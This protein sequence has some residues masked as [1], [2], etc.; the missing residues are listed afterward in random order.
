MN[1]LL[2]LITPCYL[3]RPFRWLLG[4]FWLSNLGDG[5]LLAAGPLLVASQTRSPGLVALATILQRLPWM[6][7]G[8][9]A[10]FVADRFDRRM[11]AL[12]TDGA[13]IAVLAFLGGLVALDRVNI[14]VVLV[15]LF[16]IGVAEAFS[17]TAIDAM[18]PSLVADE[19]LG[20]ANARI[21]F[22]HMGLN[23]LA[24]PPVGALLFG[25]G[26]AVPFMA[27]VVLLVAALVCL[28]Q[29]RLPVIERTN[30][31]PTTALTDIKEGLVWLWR[32]PPVRTLSL[33]LTTLNVTFG[34]SMAVLVLY[35]IE[36]LDMGKTGFGLLLAASAV[37]GLVGSA[38]YGWL[39]SR[40]SL[41]AILRAVLIT[42]TL[43]HLGLALATTG[44][45]AMA[46]Y[47]VFGAEASVW[48]TTSRSLRQ[49][50]VPEELQGR[51]GAAYR[52]LGQTGMVTGSVIAGVLAGAFGVLAPYWF[53]F[54]G[55][56]VIVALIWSQIDDVANVE[57]TT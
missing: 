18:T 6:I 12:V 51:I 21:V 37:G 57:P 20:I 43:T 41:A 14:A 25:V 22:G 33:A 49:R 13:R 16:L 28:A 19:Y 34:A 44:W 8:L 7:F 32:N 42:E 39:E 5:L 15:A 40:F 24:G 54:V 56:V 10:G 31:Q 55:S 36:H 45:M 23:N 4:S 53:A 30:T 2:E 29:L 1:R 47:V 50:A 17:D 38:S 46:V 9:A 3:G 48:G 26:M 27:Q 52:M 35:A 11:V